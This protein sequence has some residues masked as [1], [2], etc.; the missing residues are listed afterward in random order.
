MIGMLSDSLR[1]E[2]RRTAWRALGWCLSGAWLSVAA[3][4]ASTAAATSL[5]LTSITG[6]SA[7]LDARTLGG[8]AIVTASTTLPAVALS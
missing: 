3:S 6:A 8:G 5:A 7:A 1:R 4:A 2:G